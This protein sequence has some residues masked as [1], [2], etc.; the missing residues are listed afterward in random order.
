MPPLKRSASMRTT[1]SMVMKKTS[2]YKYF[3]SLFNVAI[4]LASLV[5]LVSG[6]YLKVSYMM[7]SFDFIDANFKV[8]PYMLIVL[9]SFMFVVSAISFIGFGT[10]YKLPYIIIAV[11]MGILSLTLLGKNIYLNTIL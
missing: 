6:A 2:K 11:I 10:D 4:L 7:D 1:L 8:V 5:L 3:L 9:G